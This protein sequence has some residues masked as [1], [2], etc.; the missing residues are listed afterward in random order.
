MLAAAVTTLMN[1]ERID[2]RIHQLVNKG[3]PLLL[4][5][6][7]S[8]ECRPGPRGAVVRTRDLSLD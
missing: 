8:R 7:R 6:K 4:E 5:I 2:K 1:S 3:G